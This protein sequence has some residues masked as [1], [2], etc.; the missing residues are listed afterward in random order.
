MNVAGGMDLDD[1][2][3]FFF[4]HEHIRFIRRYAQYLEVVRGKPV[5]NDFAAAGG[6]LRWID[7]LVDSGADPEGIS[8]LLAREK[9]HIDFLKKYPD[10]GR[11]AEVI[12]HLNQ[13]YGFDVLDI[14][15]QI[16]EGFEIDNNIIQNGIPPAADELKKRN[17]SQTL[18]GFKLLTLMRYGKVFDSS[19]PLEELMFHWARYDALRD[20]DEDLRVGLVLFS[21]E[22]LDLYEVKLVQGHM[23]PESFNGFYRA[24]KSETIKGLLKTAPSVRDMGLNIVEG[25]VLVSYFLSRAFKLYNQDCAIKPGLV[26][27][28]TK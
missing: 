13:S 15:K 3:D 20:I 28:S 23:V 10:E 6:Y 24:K 16:I 27:G 4:R 9:E 5:S 2:V 21:R 18:N 19:G 12:S 1:A 22:E 14:F 25:F 17:L 11:H 8:C 7:N 26:Y